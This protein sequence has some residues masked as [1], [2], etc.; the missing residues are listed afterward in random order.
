MRFE[1]INNISHIFVS[2]KNEQEVLRAIAKA[3][4][5]LAQPVGMGFIH[6]NENHVLTNE[7]ADSFISESFDGQ[8]II[9]LEMD[10]VKG[11]QCKTYVRK[12]EDGHFVLLNNVYERDRGLPETMLQ[13]A[14]EILE[15][16]EKPISRDEMYKGESLTLCL[17]EYGYT[18][19]PGE[20]DWK[21]RQRIFPDFFL[22]V[23]ERALEFLLGASAS[24]WNEID[25]ALSLSLMISGSKDKGALIHFAEGFAK[26]PMLMRK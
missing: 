9:V 12:I 13:K 25:T 20:S 5:A 8:K 16:I 24:D 17:K 7:E 3:S 2:Q 26:D 4:F 10:Y 11:R 18:R 6:F 14:K 15:G 19:L 23:P 1:R 22:K 21:F